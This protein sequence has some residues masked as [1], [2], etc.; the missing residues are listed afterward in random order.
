METTIGFLTI[1]QSPRGDVVPE[2]VQILGRNVRIVERGAL[3]ALSRPEI[4]KLRPE[5]GDLT[6]VTKLRDGSPIVVGKR[7]ILPLLRK[8]LQLMAGAHV[9]LI[10]LLCTDEFPG[11][12]PKGILLQPSRLL[13]R[14]IVTRL[15]SGKLGIFVPLDSQK[16]AATSKWR[17]T[18]LDLVVEALN[19]YEVSSQYGQAMERMSASRIDLVV[20]DCIGYSLKRAETIESG[21]K[22]TVLN[23]LTVLASEIKKAIWG[24]PE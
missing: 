9:R 1:G 11:L 22:R 8:Q 13:H 23:P 15:K 21:L 3:D 6:L 18:G 2:I 14:A 5:K 10:A 19:P 4:L 7:K 20:L 12:G 24:E 17:K 16:E